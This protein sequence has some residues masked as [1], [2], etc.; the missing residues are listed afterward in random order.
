MFSLTG[1]AQSN[2]KSKETKTKTPKEVTVYICN[3]EGAYAF[4]SRK[5]CSG[6]KRCKHEVLALTKSEAISSYGRRACKKCY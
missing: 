6:L 3:S 5:G 2:T 1:I 4:H